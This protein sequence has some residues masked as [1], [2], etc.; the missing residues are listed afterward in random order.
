MSRNLWNPLSV[1]TSRPPRRAKRPRPASTRLN[2]LSLEERL[3]QAQLTWTGLAATNAWNL[4]ANWTNSAGQAQLPATNGT[5]ELIFPVSPLDATSKTGQT[6]GFVNPQFAKIT[7]LGNG[8]TVN[9]GG[10]FSLAAGGTIDMAAASG[11]NT[12][13]AGIT[14]NGVS[15]SVSVASGGQLNL[16]GAVGGSTNIAKVDGGIL[17]LGGSNTGFTGDVTVGAGQLTVANANALGTTTGATQV[18][19]GGTLALASGIDVTTAESLTLLAGATFRGLGGT[20]TWAGP[21]NAA[22]S[23]TIQVDS[24]ASLQVT[25]NLSGSGAVAKTGPGVLELRG[26]NN[27]YGGNLTVVEGTLEAHTNSA[28]GNT[29]GTTTVQDGATLAFDPSA[30]PL[31][32]AERILLHG[33]DAPNGAL[34]AL[35]GDTVTLT[36][37]IQLQTDSSIRS[38]GDLVLSGP[39]TGLGALKKIGTGALTFAGSTPNDYGGFSKRI[40]TRVEDGVLNLNKSTTGIPAGVIGIPGDL[41]IESSGA[42]VVLIPGRLNNIVIPGSGSGQIASGADVFVEFFGLLD[43]NGNSNTIHSLSLDAGEVATGSGT[44]T[45]NGNVSGSGEIS[46]KLSFAS[47]QRTITVGTTIPTETLTVSATILSSAGFVKAGPGRLRLTGN[48]DYT[49]VTTVT[50]GELEVASATAL[51]R[52]GQFISGPT[53]GSTTDHGTR[54]EA[55]ATIAIDGNITVA[56]TL[57]LEDSTL[58]SSSSDTPTWTGP[59]SV[60]GDAT[61]ATL[62]VQG[63]LTLATGIVGRTGGVTKTGRGTLIYGGSDGN[64]YF[65]NTTV[66]EGTLRLAKT[67]GFGIPGVGTATGTLVV[68][69]DATNV[70]PAV[71]I[72][73]DDGQT[74]NDLPVSI[75]P[76]GTLNLN[77]H[78]TSIHDLTMSGGNVQTG[79]GVLSVRDGGSGITA[80]SNQAPAS[81]SGILNLGQ[82]NFGAGDT[83]FTV[84]DGPFTGD[85]VITAEIRGGKPGGTGLG[86]QA[87]LV[88][89]GAGALFLN[90]NNTYIGETR[91]EGGTLTVNYLGALSSSALGTTVSDGATLRIAVGGTFNEP[92]TLNGA[93]VGNAGALQHAASSAIVW[94]GPITLA[95]NATVG[96]SGVSTLTLAN[97]VGGGG[98]LNK[99]DVGT[100]VMT[101]DSV[102]GIIQPNNYTGPTTVGAGVLRITTPTALGAA[103]VGTTVQSGAALEVQGGITVNEGLSINGSGIN[104]GGALRNTS[105]NNTWAG[106]IILASD[107]SIGGSTGTLTLSNTVGGAGGFTKVGNT[108][109]VVFAGALTNTYTGPTVVSAG[110][111]R[112]SK[113]AGV[114][115]V[116]GNLTISSGAPGG[117]VDVANSEQIPNTAAVSVGTL[118]ELR[119]NAPETIGPLNMNSGTVSAFATGELILNGDVT[120][121]GTA[122]IA[123]VDLGNAPRRFTINP[124]SGRLTL[125]AA[126]GGPAAT[127]TKDGPGGLFLSTGFAGTYTGATVINDGIVHLNGGGATLASSSV[128]VNSNGTLTGVGTVNSVNVVGGALRPGDVLNLNGGGSTPAVGTLTVYGDLTLDANA[129]LAV[130]LNGTVPGSSHDQIR[131]IGANRTVNLGSALLTGTAGTSLQISDPFVIISDESTGATVPPLST[132]VNGVRDPV[133]PGEPQNFT[134]GGQQFSVNYAAGS[135]NDV[136]LSK[137]NTS[138]AFQNRTITPVVDEGGVVTVSG[139]I[140]EPD[141]RDRFILEVSWGAGSKLETFK[142]PAGSHGRRVDVTHRYEDDGLYAVQLFW[143]DQHGAGN[144]ATLTTTVRNAAPLVDA[145]GNETVKPGGVLNRI[146][147]FIDPG[148]DTWTATVDYGDGSGAQT[149][150]FDRKHQFHLHHRYD[151]PGTYRVV[152]TVMDDDGGIG[153]SVF[154]V[155]VRKNGR[156]K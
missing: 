134:I 87:N 78:S 9:S 34:R 63:V 156:H 129:T 8:Y 115:A 66:R 102:L 98:G 76:T 43:L 39:I 7:Y 41:L 112:L 86:D 103:S 6:V 37:T 107:A 135:G 111:L 32:S 75:L 82:P 28:L 138:A 33:D 4:A 72:F 25:G 117:L 105:G 31:T 48:S 100:L 104:G 128:T 5:D 47:V 50:A 74:S 149:L 29:T 49:G 122:T 80:T 59:M 67:S 55:G 61:V 90:G 15:T 22:G 126:E 79:A 143:H 16:N 91:V 46:G 44:L 81:I 125:G 110:T 54:V 18:N 145:G 11:T 73:D 88:K 155:T 51:G 19:G 85:L 62:G 137:E 121:N 94:D 140:V 132:D 17:S 95:T 127:L 139:T 56:E 146:G 26:T 3:A 24:S 84:S 65:G 14:F 70:N 136:R 2:L 147:S 83:I 141:P 96:V 20:M 101:E 71:V 97:R 10:A 53:E 154:F 119:L 89:R 124:F 92:L 142:F 109:T 148:A 144:R 12:I 40:T 69:Q 36:G 93:G 152:V 68:G 58:Q 45:V 23:A 99:I 60:F 38:N 35:N 120:V 114:N 118:A 150:T 151:R 57:I 64:S 131:V 13:S 116:P 52:P 113:N 1:S 153:T 27:T 108:N 106:R 123:K 130:D 133:L 21:I 30:G 42:S 77:G